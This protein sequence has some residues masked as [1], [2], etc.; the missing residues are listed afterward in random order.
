MYVF[1]STFD[2]L[3]LV[4]LM[5]HDK[6]AENIKTAIKILGNIGSKYQIK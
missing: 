3:D 5:K 2:L 4:L 6:N 1:S